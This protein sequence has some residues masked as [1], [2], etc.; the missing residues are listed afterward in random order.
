MAEWVAIVGDDS[1]ITG[2]MRSA[3]YLASGSAAT[4]MAVDEALAVEIGETLHF[5]G[6]RIPAWVWSDG[7]AVLS[8]DP[9]PVMHVSVAGVDSV[10]GMPVVDMGKPARITVM[11][12]DADGSQLKLSGNFYVLAHYDE[13]QEPI[14]VTLKDGTYVGDV[15]MPTAAIVRLHPIDETYRISGDSGFVV[16]RGE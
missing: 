4:A 11:A 3:E 10:R 12:R 6:S 1:R 8:E 14:R 7:A 16:A 5:A 15:S 9:R 2:V 13:R